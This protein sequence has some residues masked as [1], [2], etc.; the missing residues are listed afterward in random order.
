MS[1]EPGKV[2]VPYY[3]AWLDVLD[4]LT[5]V[6]VMGGL[7]NTLRRLVIE[8]AAVAHGLHAVGDSV[9]TT[10]PTVARGLCTTMRTVAD[11][12][13]IVAAHPEDLDAQAHCMDQMVGQNIEPWYHDQTAIDTARLAMLRH[14]V[15]GAAAFTPSTSTDR[16]TFGELRRA[17]QLDPTAFRAL[18][19]VLG[20]LVPPDEVYQDPTLITLIRRT[21]AQGT[22]VPSL[23]QPSHDELNNALS[24]PRLPPWPA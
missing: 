21:L 9:C 15:L 13:D 10:N 22:P 14:T 4:P 2:S 3:A 11:L 24:S 19:R 16:I 20:M 5:E 18:W 6:S 23:A 1:A 8:G 17:S 12:A 7:H